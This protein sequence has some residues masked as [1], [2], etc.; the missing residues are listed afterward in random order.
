MKHSYTE[1]TWFAI[2]LRKGGYGV[3]IVARE[4]GGCILT[5]CF[6]PC[7]E[8]VPRLSEISRLQSIT[9]ITVLRAGDL[10]LVR[11]KWPVIGN[12]TFWNRLDWPMPVFIRRE[13]LPPFRNW[14]IHYS[15]NDPSELIKQELEPAER[16]DL[17]NDGLS[18]SGAVEIMKLLDD[19]GQSARRTP[20]FS[21]PSE[22]LR[23]P[24]EGGPFR[25]EV[26]QHLH[27][28]GSDTGKT[29]SFDFYLYFPLE[30]TAH[31]AAERVREKGFAAEV[32]LRAEE[33]T[34]LCRASKSLIPESGP[35]DEIDRFIQEVAN[36][37][38]GNF[39]GWESDVVK[40]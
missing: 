6:G 35:L 15:D 38:D 5:Y 23:S 36:T 28:F 24:V 21:K 4:R 19:S 26:L 12:A 7:R 10:G 13:I 20:Q 18:G 2:P 1:G 3:G 17:P 33:G 8:A 27:S 40:P 22:K 31:K 11:G 30:A 37:L 25:M 16:L 39:D 14:R 9:A 34:W 32:R 29:H